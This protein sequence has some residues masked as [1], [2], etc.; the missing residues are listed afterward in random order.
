MQIRTFF[1]CLFPSHDHAVTPTKAL[2]YIF[3]RATIGKLDDSLSIVKK[4]K[5]IFG[6]S[7]KSAKQ[8]AKESSDFQ[9]LR[10]GFF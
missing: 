1:S 7:G 9:A 6:V 2:D 10:T 5:T 8:A 4:L 3:G